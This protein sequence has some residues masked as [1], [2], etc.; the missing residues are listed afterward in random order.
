MTTERNSDTALYIAWDEDRQSAAPRPLAAWLTDNPE[1]TAELLYWA[2]TA[3]LLDCANSSP[4]DPALEARTRAIGRQVVAEM[5]ARYATPALT[6]LV[7]AA[8]RQGMTAKTLAARL[9]VGISI[10]AKLNQ[11]LFNAASLPETLIVRL[12]ETL[13]TNAGT[14]RAYLQQSPTL[15]TGVQYKADGVP[16]VGAAEEFAAAI[17]AC[18]DMTDA[19]KA[20]WAGEQAE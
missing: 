14:V 17:R 20:V 5:R 2:G 7:E 16:H 15:A 11:R 12:A 8:K 6:N 4:D 3:P 13:Q 9:D 1:H 10:V 19:Q 18:R